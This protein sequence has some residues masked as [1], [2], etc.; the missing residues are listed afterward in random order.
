LGVIKKW[1]NLMEKSENKLAKLISTEQYSAVDLIKFY[2]F[3]NILKG[4]NI[5]LTMVDYV[6][7]YN[8]EFKTNKN[9]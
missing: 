6:R 4:M 1:V 9:N 8:N 2:N 3:V 5:N 7:K